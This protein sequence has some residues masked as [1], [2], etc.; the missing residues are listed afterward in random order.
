MHTE[1]ARADI[2]ELGH[3]AQQVEAH[4]KKLR[5]NAPRDKT[6]GERVKRCTAWRQT[7]KSSHQQ[8]VPL[9]RHKTPHEEHRPPLSG[10]TVPRDGDP[11]APSSVSGALLESRTRVLP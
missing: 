5:L 8:D 4:A 10:Q 9:P 7:L 2:V 11:D 6:L 3:A 1:H